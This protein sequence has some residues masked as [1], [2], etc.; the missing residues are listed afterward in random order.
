[1]TRSTIE[2]AE[3]VAELAN[4]RRPLWRDRLGRPVDYDRSKL[5]EI[6]RA[7]A[8]AGLLGD[9][10]AMRVAESGILAL[11]ALWQREWNVRA[12]IDGL[13]GSA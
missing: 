5:G 8:R 9:D 1:M 12:N 10:S 4:R 11:E 6:A 13:V 2:W 3:I 7:S